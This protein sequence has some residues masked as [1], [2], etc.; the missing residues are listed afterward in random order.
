MKIHGLDQKSYICCLCGLIV[1]FVGSVGDKNASP[2]TRR[3]NIASCR[4]DAVLQ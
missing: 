1:M 4:L 2:V 3:V